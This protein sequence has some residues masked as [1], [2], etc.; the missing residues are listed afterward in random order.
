[1][2]QKIKLAPSILSANFCVLSEEIKSISTT[3]YLHID[4]MDGDFVPNISLGIPVIKSIRDITD[5]IFDIH[6]MISKP[7]R[8]IREFILAGGD[9]ITVHYEA[10]SSDQDLEYDLRLIKSFNK[11][12]AIA[13]KPKTNLKNI[14]SLLDR[15]LS[16]KILDMILIMSVEPGFGGQ[17][18]IPDTLSKA[19][20]LRDFIL[21]NKFDDVDIEMDGGINLDNINQVIQSG[22]NIV[23][24]GSSI[25]KSKDRFKTINE[26][27]KKIYGAITD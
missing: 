20:E 24:A 12:S 6:L 19:R 15:F 1:M 21:E 11:K 9:I 22:V 27:Y 26:F 23:V 16:Q 3:D 18:L 25:F 2:E 14:Y 7:N 10:Y 5:M 8:Y 13:I 4:V 17:K